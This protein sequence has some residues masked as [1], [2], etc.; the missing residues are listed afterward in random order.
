MVN[1]LAKK[2]GAIFDWSWPYAHVVTT[3]TVLA[4]QRSNVEIPMDD[5]CGKCGNTF[6]TCYA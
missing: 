1:S 2:L 3:A 5:I 6:L 4:M